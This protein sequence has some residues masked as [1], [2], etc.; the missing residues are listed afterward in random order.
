LED[1]LIPTDPNDISKGYSDNHWVTLY[2][3]QFYWMVSEDIGGFNAPKTVQY[4]LKH[5]DLWLNR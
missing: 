1:F 4:G 2:W 5:E 3:G